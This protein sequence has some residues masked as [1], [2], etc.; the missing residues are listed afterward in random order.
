[1]EEGQD[2]QTN[3]LDSYVYEDLFPPLPQSSNPSPTPDLKVLRVYTS[4]ITQVFTVPFEERRFEQNDSFGERD[5][6]RLCSNIM[7]ETDTMIELSSNRDQS[8]TF[9]VTGKNDNV[10]EARRKILSNFQTQASSNIQI[11]KE[12]HRCIL[13]KAATRLKELEKTTATKISVPPQSDPSETITVTGPREGIEKAILEIQIIS[14]E[15]AKK[16]FEKIIIPRVF[17]PFI[18]GPNN[19][20]VKEL[21]AKTDTRINIPPAI[22]QSDEINITGEKE[23]VALAKKQI[24]SFYEYIEKAYTTVGVEVN[25]NQ[26]RFVIGHRGQGIADIL[27]RTGVSV[28]MPPLESPSGTVTLRG[29]QDKLGSALN[30]VYEKANSVS[31]ETVD[32]PAWIHKYII[33]RKGANIKQITQDF[34]NVHVQFDVKDGKI[35]IEGTPSD[36]NQAKAKLQEL[37]SEMINKLTYTTINVDPKYVKH[38]IG[39]NGANI[40][41]LKEQTGVVLNFSDSEPDVIR[42]EGDK[43]GVEKAQKE[44]EEM[45][46]KMEIEKE[47]DAI[48]EWK[49]HKMLIGQRG[50]SIKETRE[51]FPT[52]Q[53]VFRPTEEKSDIVK[54]RGPKEDVDKCYK[55]LLKRVK[56]LVE[57][58]HSAEIPA[59]KNCSKFIVGKGGATIKRIRE[60]TQTNIEM[61]NEEGKSGV[62]T[63][64]GKKENVE[65]AKEMIMKIQNEQIN[66]VTEEVAISP[67]IY[68]S[69]IG[70]GGKLIRGIT[71]ECGG[72]NIKFPTTDS[73]SDKVLV[74]G[75]KEGVEKAKQMLL[76]H[77]SEKEL[78]SF[79]AEVKAK[80]QLHK[81]LIGKAGSNINRIRDTTNTRIMF[82]T[83]KDENRELITIMG[84][85]EDVMRAKA[86][87][88]AA[89]EKMDNLKEIKISVDTKHHKHF[90]ASRG[91]VLQKLESEFEGVSI[92]FPR[93]GVD[94]DQV[95]IRGP[96]KVIEPVRQRIVDIVQ[97][98]DDRVTITCVV[99]QRHHRFF[100]RSRRAKVRII[101]NDF[102]VRI[103]FPDRPPYPENPSYGEG[104]EQQQPLVNG[105]VS[106]TNPCD[107]IKITGKLENCQEAKK[108]LLESVPIE[109]EMEVPFEYHKGIIGTKGKA[110]KDLMANHQVNIEVPS[111]EQQLSY[112]RIIGSQSSVDEAILAIKE[113]MKEIDDDNE[114]K[115]LKSFTLPVEVDPKYHHKIIGKKGAVVIKISTQFNVRIKFPKPGEPDENIITIMGYEKDTLGA[116]EH[117]LDIVKQLDDL[118]KEP[119]EIDSRLHSR[120]IGSG[121][122]NIKR[123]MDEYG[124]EIKFPKSTDPEPDVVTIIGTAE[125]VGDAKDH[126]LDLVYDYMEDLEVENIKNKFKAQKEDGGLMVGGN[127][128]NAGVGFVVKGAPWEQQAPDT[129]S[130]QEFPIFGGGSSNPPPV[131]VPCW[132][133]HPR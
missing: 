66:I 129:A 40:N 39:K 128:H 93:N 68:N 103:Q 117:I 42:I 96:V 83:E 70:T 41:R 16:A 77:A 87:L 119:I 69:L 120:L 43:S 76:Q 133:P 47:K 99:P 86:E 22:V 94:S 58:S 85:E 84:K 46:N 2:F 10:M 118:V 73:N 4:V 61:P 29:P 57:C 123:V 37:A 65:K 12:H 82:P 107:E 88:E 112:I 110:V 91:E 28:E 45:I 24:V 71:E 102:N 106:E 20:K 27:Q 35:S 109:Y 7:K 34:N 75:T 100:I 131:S 19:E 80:P 36:V 38:I 64:T 21:M 124:V 15:Q 6:T 13:G 14:D 11:P 49:Y 97:D 127:D 111:A 105:D 74:K 53:I 81:F 78:L 30:L 122:R 32:T 116:K 89:I 3:K 31:I 67:K 17:H 23:G 126:L 104:E 9:L 5:S 54:L 50:E 113:R 125:S 62:I 79:T 51:K 18:S 132:G 33:G 60:E 95:T 8:L 114:E 121:G 55:Y 56:E 115:K 44:L 59:Y 26:H 63:I 1:M 25:K 108:A 101:E 130:T 52:V 72:V 98:L 48:I 90:L 92:S